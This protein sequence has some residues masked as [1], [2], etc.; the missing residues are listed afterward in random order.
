M[1]IIVKDIF[2]G[3][4]EPGVIST[5]YYSSG[6]KVQSGTIIAEVMIQKASFEIEAGKTGT[7]YVLLPEE[8][9]VTEGTKIGEIID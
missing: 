3:T 7:L 9:E 2:A 5:W 6:D 1:D 8:S 4:P